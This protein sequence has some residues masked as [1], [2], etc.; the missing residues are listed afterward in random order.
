ML[1]AL[2]PLIL[3]MGIVPAIPTA[4]AEEKIPKWIQNTAT[5]WSEGTISDDEFLAAIEFLI[6][7][8]VIEIPENLLPPY[9]TQIESYPP[10]KPITE[11]PNIIVIMPDDVGW[12]NIGAYNDGIMAG[13][14]PNIDKIAENGMRFTDYYA[15][16]VVLQDVQVSSLES[17]QFVQV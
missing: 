8:G 4:H 15:D 2:F 16:L 3:S 5:W 13:I 9:D 1:L 11:Q 14:T 12:Y 6:K 10:P 17:Y 7:E